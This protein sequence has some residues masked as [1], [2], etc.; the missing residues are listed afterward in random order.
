MSE[1]TDKIREL[2]Q[3]PIRCRSPELQKH[4]FNQSIDKIEQIFDKHGLPCEFIPTL[5]EQL[6][7]IVNHEDKK[8]LSMSLEELY[9][10][11]QETINLMNRI[12]VLNKKVVEQEINAVSIGKI[13]DLK[14]QVDNLLGELDLLKLTDKHKKKLDSE[15]IKSIEVRESSVS[16]SKNI[17]VIRLKKSFTLR[18]EYVREIIVL[19]KFWF[20]R[21][22]VKPPV[23]KPTN[24]NGCFYSFC[25]EI[26]NTGVTEEAIYEK[27]KNLFDMKV[28]PLKAKSE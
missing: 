18:P 15:R 11:L 8:E 27:V 4:K 3:Q 5:S 25:S 10:S 23:T 17:F 24:K 7:I 16:N 22:G 28:I 1:N 2:F 9:S 26:L 19:A 13:E 6:P 20:A 14:D 21:K 12:K